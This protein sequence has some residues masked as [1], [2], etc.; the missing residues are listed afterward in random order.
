M[1]FS[2]KTKCSNPLKRENH[3]TSKDLFDFPSNFRTVFPFLPEKAKI[4]ST[5]RRQLYKCKGDLPNVNCSDEYHRAG[6][7]VFD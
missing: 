3:P 1:D 2:C 4:C 6:V 7:T 5:C